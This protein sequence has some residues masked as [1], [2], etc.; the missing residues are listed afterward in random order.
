MSES[1]LPLFKISLSKTY[2]LC[3]SVNRLFLLS[4]TDSLSFHSVGPQLVCPPKLQVREGESLSCEVRGNPQPSVTWFR[5]GQVV[6]LPTHSSRRHAGKYIVLA[7]G[8][9]EQRNFTVEVEVLSGS[10]RFKQLL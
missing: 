4:V 7:Q 1:P 8:L 10:G 5:D 6:A 9:H 3:F 2:Q